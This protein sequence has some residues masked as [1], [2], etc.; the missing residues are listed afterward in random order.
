MMPS[1]GLVKRGW[2]S[3]IWYSGMSGR[4]SPR[5]LITRPLPEISLMS[6]GAGCSDST[7]KPSGRM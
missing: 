5:T 7:T 3:N 4:Y 6:S 2:M 1:Q